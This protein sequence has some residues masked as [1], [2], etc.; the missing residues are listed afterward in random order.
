MAAGAIGTLVS[1]NKNRGLNDLVASL[2]EDA[3]ACEG[4]CPCGCAGKGGVMTLRESWSR[5]PFP[6]LLSVRQ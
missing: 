5:R 3:D 6:R 2:F 4:A 1:R